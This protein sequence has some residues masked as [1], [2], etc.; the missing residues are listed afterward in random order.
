MKKQLCFLLFVF[1]SSL[2]FAEFN[3]GK[4][5]KFIEFDIS[6]TTSRGIEQYN[7]PVSSEFGLVSHW[8]EGVTGFQ[9]YEDSFDF[10]LTAQA[11]LPCTNWYF[12]TA[13]IA[14]GLGGIYHFQRY[15]DISSEHDYIINSTFRYQSKSGTTISFYGGYAGKATKIDVLSSYVPWIYDNYPE[16]GFSVDKIWKNGF[17]IYFHHTL[18][19]LYRYPLFC[20][21][22]YKLGAAIN[23]D[24]GLRYSG[25][26][27]VRIADG[28]ATSPYVDSLIFKLSARFSF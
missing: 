6:S 10:T 13:R 7:T 27:A 22:Q 23:L 1:F 20:S 9:A 18:N 24:S 17:E 25:D 12:E 8:W 19:D 3:D 26:I 15:K 14:L 11:W 16:A 28:Y 2:A 4:I 5:T 21:P